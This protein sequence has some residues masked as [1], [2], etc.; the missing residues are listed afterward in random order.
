M[1]ITGKRAIS[2]K[3]RTVVVSLRYAKNLST[4][5]RPKN[6]NFSVFKDLNHRPRPQS[7]DSIEERLVFKPK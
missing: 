6:H 3:N 1:N 5:K 7:S 4:E 2:A